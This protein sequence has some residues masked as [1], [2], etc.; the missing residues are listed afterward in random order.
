MPLPLLL[1]DL[2][3]QRGERHPFPRFSDDSSPYPSDGDVSALS[4]L[5]P[6]LKWGYSSINM[7]RT[8]LGV[9]VNPPLDVLFEIPPGSSSSH[10]LPG[11]LLNQ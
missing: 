11:D 2:V 5:S 9:T 8:G 3:L 7:K 10:C 6:A 4:S 1:P